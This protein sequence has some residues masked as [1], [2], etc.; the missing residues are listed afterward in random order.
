VEVFGYAKSV[1]TDKNIACEGKASQSDNYA[2]KYGF[3]HLAID[4]NTDGR[5]S[6][7]S[8]THTSK[9]GK[10]AWWRLDFS[11]TYYVSEIRIW[12]RVDCCSERLN[13]VTVRLD[14][15]KKNI[16]V[17]LN[18]KKGNPIVIK[19]NDA[20]NRITINGG[21][22]YLSLAEVEVFGHAIADFETFTNIAVKGKASQCDNWAGNQGLAHLAIDGNTDGRWNSKSVTHTSKVGE[23]AWWRLDF[24]KS[25]YVSKIRIWNRVDCCSERLNGA[26][27]RL[28]G[29][30]NTFVTLDTRKGNPIEI[31]V[32]DV[33]KRITING[34]DSYLSLAE[35]EVFGYAKPVITDKNIASEWKASIA[36]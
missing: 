35:V 21:T 5:W 29:Q 4:G 1:I 16:L 19:V 2:G 8:V 15:G 26:T 9:Q 36:G 32:D 6:S 22:S 17:T 18:I 25:Y 33:L 10:D 14:G 3:A 23:D 24:S 12:N 27:V 7:K 20:L 28:N 13:G 34:G 30:K 11:K 31:K